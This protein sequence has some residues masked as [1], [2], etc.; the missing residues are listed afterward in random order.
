MPV[1][2][3][4]MLDVLSETLAAAYGKATEA[5]SCR[6]L[7]ERIDLDGWSLYHSAFDYPA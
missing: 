1:F 6:H 7:L 2:P 4:E 5:G 3:W